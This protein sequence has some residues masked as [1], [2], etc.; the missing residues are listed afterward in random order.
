MFLPG[1]EN[2]SESTLVCSLQLVTV[3]SSYS[4]VEKMCLS[5]AGSLSYVACPPGAAGSCD[6]LIYTYDFAQPSEY[7]WFDALNIVGYCKKGKSH[8]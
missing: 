2:R 5:H 8:I 3:I 4:S 7:K 6:W 1:V